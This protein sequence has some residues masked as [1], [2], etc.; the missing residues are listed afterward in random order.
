MIKSYEGLLSQL[1]RYKTKS[2]KKSLG[3]VYSFGVDF[4]VLK[5]SKLIAEPKY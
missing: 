2:T 4:L 3:M 5:Q 1:I